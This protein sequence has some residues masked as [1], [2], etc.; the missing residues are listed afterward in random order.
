MGSAT[1]PSAA[2]IRSRRKAGSECIWPTGVQDKYGISRATFWRW[3]RAGKLPP[4][5]FYVGGKAVGWRPE[6]LEA[7]MRGQNA[8]S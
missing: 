6:T 8:A 5:D 7:A 3:V 4:R 1:S 2:P